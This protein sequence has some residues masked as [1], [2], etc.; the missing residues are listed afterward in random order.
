MSSE[1]QLGL[2]D[3]LFILKQRSLLLVSTFAGVF[4]V[5]LA[6]AL[7]YPP[8]YQAS[9]TVMVESQ[10][11]PNELVQTSVT[12]VAEERIEVIQ[13]RVMTRENLLRI[14][15]KYKLFKDMRTSYTPSE[16]IDE[17]RSLIVVEFVDAKVQGKQKGS[18]AI[19]FKLS[20]EHRDPK[21]A[22]EV[23]NELV[24]LFLNENSKVRTE[25]AAQTTE[26]LAQEGDKLKVEL[27]ALEN[28]IAAYKQEH[29]NAVPENMNM[30]MSS[31]QR[32]E[33]ELREIDREY[34]AVQEELRFL[35]LELASARAGTGVGSAPGG[36]L[37]PAQELERT[38]AEYARLSSLYT[39]NHPDV[40]A[41]KRKIEQLEKSIASPEGG[42]STARTS[43][44]PSVDR[45][46]GRIA[47]AKA[48]AGVLAQQQGALRAKLNSME[49]E[50]LKAPQVERGLSSLERDH[51]NAEKKYDEIRAKQR[52]AQVSESLEGDKKAERFTLLEPPV[53]PDS[54]I[55]P[56]RKKLIVLGFFVA[57]AAA[58]GSVILLENISGGV[59]GIE[60]LESITPVPLLA[61]I[62]Y[63]QV[64]EEVAKRERLIKRALIAAGAFLLIMLL[65]LH[66]FYLPLDILV[67][68]ALG[69]LG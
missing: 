61:V 66:I 10:Q 15:E 54:P 67:M 47:S 5:A 6:L 19:V 24:T 44:D 48:R 64:G 21:L 41:A 59:R 28:R 51:Q 38:R 34:R 46:E 30:L 18:A 63:I 33:S 37:S 31:I 42:T 4:A 50:V 62:P 53:M 65:A 68:K 60:A 23:A 14:I 1:Y 58:C 17:M 9:G 25:R 55:K 7:L 35:N 36:A 40:R 26:F 16:L 3:Y 69:R 13:Q 43:G 45:V 49:R 2:Q 8:V 29:G 27:E 56:N 39:P 11:I 32:T 12:G 52:T 57:M 20:F 22:Y